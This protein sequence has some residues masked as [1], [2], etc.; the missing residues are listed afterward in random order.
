MPHYDQAQRM[1]GVVKNPTFTDADRIM[2]D[3][4]RPFVAFDVDPNA[5]QRFDGPRDDHESL[6]LHRRAIRRFVKQFGLETS[7][8]YRLQTP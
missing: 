8:G 5:P 4:G 1:L 3:L 2:K 6:P 7:S